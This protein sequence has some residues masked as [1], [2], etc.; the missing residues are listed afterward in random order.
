[1][2]DATSRDRALYGSRRR[3]VPP[4]LEGDEQAAFG[5]GTDATDTGK[6]LGAVEPSHPLAGEHDGN[7]LAARMRSCDRGKRGSR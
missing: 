6:H 1:M 7:G 4:V 2:I 5:T 3:R